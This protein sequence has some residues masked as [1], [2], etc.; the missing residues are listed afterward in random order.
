MKVFC[1]FDLITL[2]AVVLF[3][4]SPAS[5]WDDS[6]DSYRERVSLFQPL[7][8]G[9]LIPFLGQDDEP[10][11]FLIDYWQKWSEKTGFLFGF[12]L[13]HGRKPYLWSGMESVIFR[14]GFI[15]AKSA[16]SI[17]IFSID[18]PFQGCPCHQEG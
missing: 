10:E 2:L 16:A 6:L 15:V 13:H 7:P 4:C 3:L 17:S 5:A 11:G 12:G 8:F 14:A 1:R 18:T 9:S